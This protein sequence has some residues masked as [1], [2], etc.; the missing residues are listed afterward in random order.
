MAKDD[1]NGCGQEKNNNKG[2][3]RNKCRP[4]MIAS[5]AILKLGPPPTSKWTTSVKLNGMTENEVKEWLDDWRDSDNGPILVDMIVKSI[6]M[7]NSY[8]L[9]NADEDWQSVV[10]VAF[11]DSLVIL[12]YAP[13]VLELQSFITLD[14]DKTF[15][16]YFILVTFGHTVLRRKLS[17]CRLVLLVRSSLNQCA[18]TTTIRR[19]SAVWATTYLVDLLRDHLIWGLFP[20]LF[21]NGIFRLLATI[22]PRFCH[23]T[24]APRLLNQRLCGLC[25]IID[26]VFAQ[27]HMWFKFLTSQRGYVSWLMVQRSD[28][29]HLVPSLSWIAII[30]STEHMTVSF[31]R[32][33][34]RRP[35]TFSRTRCS[36][37]S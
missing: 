10:Q 18:R 24:P 25:E 31:V 16:D 13:L 19:T 11:L 3:R 37:L 33:H 23:P 35:I 36:P 8:S 9:Y 15:S 32:Y 34:Q 30:A 14:F 7:C 5:K 21:G 17:I 1:N 20:C 29:C 28:G 12:L 27:H 2:H 22:V 6:S 26:H 4:P